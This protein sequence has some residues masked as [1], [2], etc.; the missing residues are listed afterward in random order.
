MV[1]SDHGSF[2]EDLEDL[3]SPTKKRDF[4]DTVRLLIVDPPHVMSVPQPSRLGKD[5]CGY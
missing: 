5:A 1:N 2:Q 3:L 4:V